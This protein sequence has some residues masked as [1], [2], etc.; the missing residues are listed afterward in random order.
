MYPSMDRI[1]YVVLLKMN[2]G[3]YT[4]FACWSGDVPQAFAGRGV[5]IWIG[6]SFWNGRFA[7][8]TSIKRDPPD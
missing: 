5:S 2:R 8:N 4:D 1:A 3:Y 7:N 6:I